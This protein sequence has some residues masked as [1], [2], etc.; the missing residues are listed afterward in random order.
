MVGGGGGGTKMGDS[1]SCEGG[2]LRDS[3]L[4]WLGAGI[5]SGSRVVDSVGM[6]EAVVSVVRRR[7]ARER[8]GSLAIFVMEVG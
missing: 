2:R 6:A 7:R 8:R 3:R 5:T 1:W 4:G